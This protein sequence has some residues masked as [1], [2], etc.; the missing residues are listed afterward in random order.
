LQNKNNGNCSITELK[1]AKLAPASFQAIKKFR[2]VRV[3]H[4][5]RA[6]QRVSER[7]N[8]NNGSKMA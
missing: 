8:P 6:H 5:R 3:F 1:R 2:S 4:G 7:R